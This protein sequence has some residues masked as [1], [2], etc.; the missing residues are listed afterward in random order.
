MLNGEDPNAFLFEAGGKARI[1]HRV[2]RGLDLD[3]LREVGTAKYDP[4]I[5]RRR[6]QRHV[7]LRAGMQT[8]ARGPDQI[9][10]RPLMDQLKTF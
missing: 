5:R 8:D 10:E 2:W 3:G 7:D 9:L 1:A 4:A 6:P